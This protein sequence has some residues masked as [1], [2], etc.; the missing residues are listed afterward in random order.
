MTLTHLRGFRLELPDVPG[1]L[2]TVT[3]RL[4]K[5]NVNVTGVCGLVVAG[6]G[7]AI[8]AVNDPDMTQSVLSAADIVFR[9]IPLLVTDIEDQPGELDRRLALLDDAGVNVEALFGMPSL[10]NGAAVALQV[11]DQKAAEAV[12]A[13]A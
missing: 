11:D 5:E 13:R 2:R 3:Q 4:A 7:Y 1:T 8:L 9:E 12:L 10:Y 6:K